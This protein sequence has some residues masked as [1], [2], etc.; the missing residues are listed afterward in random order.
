MVER[1]RP[2]MTTW[3]MRIAYWISKATNTHSEYVTIYT[4]PLQQWLLPHTYRACLVVLNLYVF[5]NVNIL[6][7]SVL[8]VQCLD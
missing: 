4:C 1:D 8:A 3:R 6:L 2:Q 7:I 5:Y